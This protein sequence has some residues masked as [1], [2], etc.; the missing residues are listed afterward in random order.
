MEIAKREISNLE[1]LLREGD[2]IGLFVFGKAS[3]I[4]LDLTKD[5]ET[6]FDQVLRANFPENLFND[7]T[8]F[9]TSFIT[10]LEHVYQSLDGQDAFNDGYAKGRPYNPKKRDNRIVVIFSDGEEQSLKFKPEALEEHMARTDYLKE[11]PKVLAEYRKRGL[12]IYPV[13]I[14]TRK[15]ASFLSL[16]KGYKKGTDYTEELE[17]EWAGQ[18][19]RLDKANL[20]ALAKATGVDLSEHDWTVES[21]QGNARNYLEYAMDFNR[22]L[23]FELNVEGDNEPLWQYCLLVSIIFL[24][25]GIATYPF[26]GYLRK[27]R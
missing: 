20:S 15:G 12:K 9:F 24:A 19:T 10:V 14:G 5:F 23:L 22:S 8:A 7:E 26:S 4:K 3:H 2:K 13:G 25:L 21:A 6:F 18:V 17:K 27:T 11:L 16:L 1:P